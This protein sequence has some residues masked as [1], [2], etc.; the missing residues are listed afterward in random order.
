M[1]I[2]KIAELNRIQA[3]FA[4]K[5]FAKP[6]MSP[7][8][9][10]KLDN[11][12][13]HPRTDNR[14]SWDAYFAGMAQYV[15]VRATCPRASVGCV[16]VRDKRVLTTGYNGASAG[17]PSCLDVGCLME[18]KHCISAIHAEQNAII[19]AALHGITTQGAIAYVTHCPCSLCAKM[20]I[21]AG[22]V[23]VVYINEYAPADGGEF[24]RMAGVVVER[25][26]L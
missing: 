15:S 23:R 24:F 7:I 25:I 26:E 16:L 18:D 11:L 3:D 22:I 4:A 17:L 5:R 9:A 2:G 20:L 19:Q 8:I 10:S 6:V 14:P 13:G 12:F 21:N 1:E